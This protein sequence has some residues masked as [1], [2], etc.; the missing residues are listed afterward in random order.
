MGILKGISIKAIIFGLI[1][2]LIAVLIADVLFSWV[3]KLGYQVSLKETS[4]ILYGNNLHLTIAMLLGL[5]C[6]MYGGFI[7]TT[8]SKIDNVNNAL[9]LG[10]IYALMTLYMIFSNNSRTPLWDNLIVLILII[11][12][13]YWGGLLAIKYKSYKQVTQY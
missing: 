2:Q 13:T 4:E 6:S 3:L 7:A 8:S 9:I 11:P 10:I 12:V 1:T 5:L